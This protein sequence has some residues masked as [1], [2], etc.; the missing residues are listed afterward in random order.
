MTTAQAVLAV[1][2][3]ICARHGPMNIQLG[4]VA[5]QLGI[6]TPA[7]YRHYKGNKGVIAAFA[8]VALRA[9]IETFAGIEELAFPEA[10]LKQAERM[11]DLYASRPGVG[12]F[13]MAD[14]SVPG[15]LGGFEREE[16]L[17]LVSELLG[18]EQDLLQRGIDSG[19][20]LQMSL[21]SFLAARTGSALVGF[22][23]NELLH[24]RWTVDNDTL[25]REYLETVGRLLIDKA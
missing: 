10:L 7:I 24:S 22:A 3:E 23:F 4:D 15:G 2:E 9:E 14:L 21:T 1:V 11:F 18:H 17:R 19:T 20:L 25:K 12:R 16:N 13:L 6:E 8:N 5:A